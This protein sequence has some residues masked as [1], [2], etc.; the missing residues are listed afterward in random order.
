M[1]TKI[2]LFGVGIIIL[3]LFQTACSK[4]E[5]ENGE[6]ESGI[7][8]IECSGAGV[9]STVY[10]VSNTGSDD[11]SGKSEGAAF[12]TLSKALSTV[13]QGGT[14]RIL[15]GV[16]TESLGIQYCG[17]PSSAVTIEG[18]NGIPVLDGGNNKPIALYFEDSDNFIIRNLKVINYTDIGIGFSSGSG[19]ILTN[20]EVAE[21]GH[22][23]RLIDWELE[24]YGIHV[25]F[26]ENIEI[27][28]CLVYKNGP[29]PQIVPDFIMGTGINTFGNT[30]VLIKNN[31][32]YENIGGGILVEDSY[33]VIGEDN[34]VYENDLD[35]TVD[36]WWDGGLWLDGGGNVI[37]R[38]NYFHD[39]KG[40]GIEISNEDLQN[41]TG[42]KLI[43]NI[44]N[45]NYFGI[46]IWNFGTNDWP[47]TTII[48]RSGNDFSGNSQKDVWIVDWF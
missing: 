30:N 42:Y 40:P 22:K 3:A 36:E 47:D 19:L 10:Y 34:E 14:I 28:N 35:A 7:F 5:D 25:D 33:N 46:F 38:N 21:N 12:K 44:S 17:G 45:D 48:S 32:S 6:D 27:T 15:P 41:P 26:S 11:N 13:K 37:V 43:D 24:G 39:N 2:L 9:D 1:K 18:Y 4:D 16:Y 29:D 23:V 8:W 20:L 31:K